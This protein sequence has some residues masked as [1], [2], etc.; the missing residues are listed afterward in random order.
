MHAAKKESQTGR[1]R[2][3]EV[4]LYFFRFT[5]RREGEALVRAPYDPGDVPLSERCRNARGLSKKE[6][7]SAS[8][9]PCPRAV[10]TRPS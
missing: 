4:R 8:L 3:R 2:R 10:V 6:E 9:R 5:E 7:Q 1:S